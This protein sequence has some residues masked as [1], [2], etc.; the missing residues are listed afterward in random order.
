VDEISRCDLARTRAGDVDA[1]PR[2]AAERAQG[3]RASM[4]SRQSRFV[5]SLS[6]H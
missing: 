2:R 4:A 6:G 1:S 3:C 5:T